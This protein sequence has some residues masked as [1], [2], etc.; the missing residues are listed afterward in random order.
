M[1]PRSPVGSYFAGNMQSANSR[2]LKILDAVSFANLRRYA[3]DVFSVCFL[4]N[5]I[6]RIRWAKS[7]CIA[8][9]PWTS[10]MIKRIHEKEPAGMNFWTH[11]ACSSLK[12]RHNS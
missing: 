5:S 12:S 9:F 3:I 10:W 7:G 6:M 1:S 8:S 4:Y 2:K 11:S